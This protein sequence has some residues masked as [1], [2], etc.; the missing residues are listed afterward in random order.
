MTFSQNGFFVFFSVETATNDKIAWALRAYE[1]WREYRN[2]LFDNRVNFPVKRATRYIWPMI[3]SARNSEQLSTDMCDFLMEVRKQNGDEYPGQTLQDCIMMFNLYLEHENFEINLLSMKQYKSV[4]N[5]LDNLMKQRKSMGLGA[6]HVKDIVTEEYEEILWQ[7]G[8]LGDENPDVLRRT[9]FYL[10]GTRFGLRGGKEHRN[11]VRYPKSQINIETVNSKECLVYREFS[12]KSNA[13]GVGKTG[14]SN[15]KVGYAFCSGYEPRCIIEIYKKYQ[16]YC[17]KATGTWPDFYLQSDPS[18]K[19][20]NDFWYLNNPVGSNSLNVY[21]R[22][23][24]ELA[25]IDGYF[26]N[27]SLRATCASRLYQ[28][29][30]DEQLIAET[31]GHKS[32][33]VGHYKRTN[34]E[35]KE[36][37]SDLLNV[38]PK[39]IKPSKTRSG[40]G[41]ISAQKGAENPPQ[42]AV[43]TVQKTEKTDQVKPID[44]DVNLP[45]GFAGLND[46]KGMININFHFH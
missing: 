23:M 22:D 32:N 36:Q 30:V 26:T 28:K 19:R 4:R 37:I 41:V 29:S 16:F 46:L 25:G 38:I 14:T 45:K 10:I 8:V 2:E 39:D 1:R 7:K 34:F 18:F 13:G 24:M 9:M 40:V 31:T 17:P 20:E 12:S 42:N 6:T 5:T 15:D 33:A 44:L 27:H 35:Q 43:Q 11:L 21:V 3:R